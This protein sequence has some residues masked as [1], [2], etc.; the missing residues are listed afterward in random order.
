V[1]FAQIAH[2]FFNRHFR[3]VG[4]SRSLVEYRREPLRGSDL[5]RNA[6]RQSA[7]LPWFAR[8]VLV[9]VGLRAH[10]PWFA[11]LLG[12]GDEDYPF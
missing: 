4:R 5:F 7:S 10:A 8:N 12:H 3:Y 9:K 6:A 1:T 2:L 11:G